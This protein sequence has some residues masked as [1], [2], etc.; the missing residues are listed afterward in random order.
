MQNLSKEKLVASRPTKKIVEVTEHMLVKAVVLETNKETT[1]VIDLD[2]FPNQKNIIG[3][4]IGET[5]K[6]SGLSNMFKTYK[7]LEIIDNQS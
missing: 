2:R 5:F 6:L 3:K 4:R 7:I 1:M